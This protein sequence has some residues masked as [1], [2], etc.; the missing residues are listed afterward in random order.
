MLLIY[1]TPREEN[2]NGSEWGVLGC[3]DGAFRGMGNTGVL[4]QVAFPP[5]LVVMPRLSDPW[6]GLKRPHQSNPTLPIHGLPHQ[7]SERLTSLLPAPQ[8]CKDESPRYYQSL[9]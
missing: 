3:F 1:P 7:F 5:S 8:H 4:P 9:P 2:N 6:M